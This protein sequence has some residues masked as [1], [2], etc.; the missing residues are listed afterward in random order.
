M[1]ASD[2]FSLLESFHSHTTAYIKP[3][4]EQ[5]PVPGQ[6]S[7]EGGGAYLSPLFGWWYYL[8]HGTTDGDVI[9]MPTCPL[10]VA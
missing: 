9:V 10:T 2:R 8:E 6:R 5:S 4:L 7:K 3:V 1:E